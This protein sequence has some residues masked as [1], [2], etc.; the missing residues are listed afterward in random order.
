[1]KWGNS[2]SKPTY[3]HTF[4]EHGQK[5]KPNQLI[6]RAKSKSHQVGQYQND[7]ATAD[8]IA[9]VA[10]KGPGVHNVPLP[11]TV[12][13]RGYFGDGTVLVPDMARI[14]LKPDDSVRTSFPYSSS[15]P[16]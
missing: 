1:M 9:E 7:Q 14:A 3:G 13:A 4:N 15:Y 2:K 10:K 6:D 11:P 16:N 8:F 5:L 12:S